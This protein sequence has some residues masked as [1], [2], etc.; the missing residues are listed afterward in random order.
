MGSPRHTCRG[1]FGEGFEAVA[2]D[3]HQLRDGG[4]VQVDL[5]HLDVAEVGRQHCGLAIDVDTLGVPGLDTSHHHAVPQVM[6]ASCRV[7]PDAV[8]PSCRR[9]M[10]KV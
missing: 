2:D 3:A 7:R 9:S 1:L 10:V 5:A 8:Q 6:H 4:E